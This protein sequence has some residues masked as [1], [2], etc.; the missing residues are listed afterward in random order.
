ME[1]ARSYALL[2]QPHTGQNA[3]HSQR[4][5]QVWLASHTYPALVN[6]CS[7][8]IGLLEERNISFRIKAQDLINDF[9]KPHGIYPCKKF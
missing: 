7:K 1:Q 4:M 2:I 3:C 9:K 5:T 6:L 8:H